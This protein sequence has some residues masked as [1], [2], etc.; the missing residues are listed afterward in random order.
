MRIKT[1][2]SKTCGLKLLLL[3][4]FIALNAYMERQKDLPYLE[5]EEETKPK[6]NRGKEIIVE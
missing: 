2:E 6:A 4:K 3:L 5:K 1:L